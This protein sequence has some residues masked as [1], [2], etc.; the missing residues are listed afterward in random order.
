MIGK[1]TF[2]ECA[3]PRI[4]LTMPSSVRLMG[5]ISLMMGS[6]TITSPPPC[7]RPRVTFCTFQRLES[8]CVLRCS[9]TKGPLAEM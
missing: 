8:A 3:M 5:G 6:F 1:G 9:G 4:L 2:M 7:S